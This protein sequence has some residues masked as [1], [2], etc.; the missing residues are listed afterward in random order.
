MTTR[1]PCP[2][3][4]YLLLVG[5]LV[6]CCA[7]AEGTFLFDWNKILQGKDDLAACHPFDALND[8]TAGGIINHLQGIL[9]KPLDG[10]LR[11]YVTCAKETIGT[12]RDIHNALL[13][14]HPATI[15]GGPMLYRDHSGQTPVVIDEA[16][17]AEKITIVDEAETRLGEART[18]YWAS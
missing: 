6:Y 15:D 1:I 8:A 10:P 17:L 13:H 9:K 11:D 7:Y 5:R 4:G 18:R 2:S 3:D 14:S 12:I 16:W